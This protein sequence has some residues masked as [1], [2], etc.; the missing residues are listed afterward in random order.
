M[1]KLRVHLV[2]GVSKLTK[3][4]A[5]I[6]YLNIAGQETTSTSIRWALLL[7]AKNQDV[8]QLVHEEIDRIVGVREPNSADRAQMPYTES[9]LN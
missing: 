8:Q 9:V 4:N 5:D 3:T 2:I 1:N 7:I 6:Y